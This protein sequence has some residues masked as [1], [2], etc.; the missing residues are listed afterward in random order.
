[1]DFQQLK[2]INEFILE[3]KEKISNDLKLYN[4]ISNLIRFVFFMLVFEFFCLI[5]ILS[6]KPF[7]VTMVFN[8][9]FLIVVLG[10]CFIWKIKVADDIII[11][12]MML[13]Y[14]LEQRKEEFGIKFESEQ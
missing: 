13:K 6:Y 7:E 3:E 9:L 5:H 14:L 12:T 11:K 8:F 2:L 4:K 1:M 10:L